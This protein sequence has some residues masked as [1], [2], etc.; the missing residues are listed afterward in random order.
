MSSVCGALG[1][2]HARCEIRKHHVGSH[3]GTTTEGEWVQW[4]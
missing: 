4:H 2:H 1:P 3:A